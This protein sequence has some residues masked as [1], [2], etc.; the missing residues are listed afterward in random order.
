[1][2]IVTSPCAERAPLGK[3]VGKGGNCFGFC[4]AL[5]EL[6][7]VRNNCGGVAMVGA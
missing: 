2:N 6:D 4:F 1:M 5:T 3:H 7:G